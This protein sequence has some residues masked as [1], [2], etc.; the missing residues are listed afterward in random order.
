MPFNEEFD[1]VYQELI[2]LPLE[3]KQASMAFDDIDSQ[4]HSQPV[5]M[6]GISDSDI[7]IA[8]LTA[9]NP[10][11]FYELGIAHAVGKPVVLLTQSIEDVPFEFTVGQFDSIQHP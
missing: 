9:S 1:S 11:V 5:I 3:E 7:I 4:E 2:K 8:D 6:A 10:N